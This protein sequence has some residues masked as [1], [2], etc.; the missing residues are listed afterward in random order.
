MITER[1]MPVL[2]YEDSYEVSNLGRIWSVRFERF[3]RPDVDVSGYPRVCLSVGRKQT[4]PRVHRLVVLAFMGPQPVGHQVNHKDGNKRNSALSNLEWVTPSENCLHSFRNGM[5]D[6]VGTS[7]GRS[8][9]SET[10]V[11]EIRELSEEGMSQAQ[12]GVLYEIC[13]QHVSDIVT[14]KK[15]SHI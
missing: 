6:A 14:K 1:W 4:T 8:R 3:L 2:N 13:Q 11:L 7:N 10:Q 9:L 12:I 15:W 5:S